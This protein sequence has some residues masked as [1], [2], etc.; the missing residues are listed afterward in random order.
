MAIGETGLDYF[1]EHSPRDEQ[2]ASFEAEAVRVRRE[3]GE[4]EPEAIRANLKVLMPYR[5]KISAIADELAELRAADAAAH[6]S[7]PK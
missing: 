1:Y 3:A 4:K 2:I 7:P 6:P 5:Q